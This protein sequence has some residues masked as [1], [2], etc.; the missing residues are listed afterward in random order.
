M[1]L[2]N[3]SN[4]FLRLEIGS[5]ILLCDVWTHNGIYEGGWAIHPPV[6]DLSNYLQ[7]CT[8]LFLSLIHI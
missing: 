5:S 6:E 1:K 2:Q 8:H 7:G 3:P 4:G